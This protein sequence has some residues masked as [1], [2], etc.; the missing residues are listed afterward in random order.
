LVERQG[1]RTAR[2]LYLDGSKLDAKVL[3]LVPL[4]GRSAVAASRPP[5]VQGAA[6]VS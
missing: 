6:V 1:A 4:E 2:L 3:A 5:M